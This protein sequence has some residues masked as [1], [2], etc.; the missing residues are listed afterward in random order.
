[1][2]KRR[3]N[4]LKFFL[5]HGGDPN[6]RYKNERYAVKSTLLEDAIPHPRDNCSDEEK[7]V[8]MELMRLLIKHGANVNPRYIKYSDEWHVWTPLTRAIQYNDF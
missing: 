7:A 6:Y 3:V 2:K 4:A 5:E 8:S 1:M